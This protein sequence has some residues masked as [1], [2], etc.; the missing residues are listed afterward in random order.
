LEYLI[1]LARDLS[2]WKRE[3]AEALIA[4]TVEVRK[5]LFG[6]LRTT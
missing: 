6:L 1:V 4:D 5:V 3:I 2:Y